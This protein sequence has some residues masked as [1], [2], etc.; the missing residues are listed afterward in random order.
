MRDLNAK[1]VSAL[2]REFSLT[3]APHL[4]SETPPKDTTAR[5]I[6]DKNGSEIFK[7][8]KSNL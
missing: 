7:R 3:R 6:E 2:A 1:P 5:G 4:I 8:L